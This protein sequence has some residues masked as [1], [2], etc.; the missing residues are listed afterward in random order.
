MKPISG[1]DDGIKIIWNFRLLL[2]EYT[3]VERGE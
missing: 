2:D 3:V 1:R